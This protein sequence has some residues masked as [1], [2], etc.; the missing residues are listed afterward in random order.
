MIGWK[1]STAVTLST[2]AT[3]STALSVGTGKVTIRPSV[4][5]YIE[6]SNS[7]TDVIDDAKSTRLPANSVMTI[8]VPTFKFKALNK[9]KY[10]FKI[11]IG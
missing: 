7:S 3:T 4:D 5:V 10:L 1:Q 2:D 8:E 11:F 9:V 6:F